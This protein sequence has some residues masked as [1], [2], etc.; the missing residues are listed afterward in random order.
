MEQQISHV[1]T[2]MTVGMLTVVGIL[3][4]VVFSGKMLVLIL[5]RT[6]FR[7][8]RADM[9]QQN[10]KKEEIPQAI[11]NAAIQKWSSG[12]ATP[13]SIKRIK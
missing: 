9:D 3:A 8:N 6:G 5:N 1:L 10:N 4:L 2:I 13:I 11:I 12:K 7:L